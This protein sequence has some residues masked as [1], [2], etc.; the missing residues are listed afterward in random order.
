MT[1]EGTNL[2]TLAQSD[3]KCA[4]GEMQGIAFR[5]LHSI[6]CLLLTLPPSLCIII[7]TQKICILIILKQWAHREQR[8]WYCPTKSSFCVIIQV[9]YYMLK[10]VVK[11]LTKVI[12]ILGVACKNMF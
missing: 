4:L 2:I 10:Q 12:N 9:A 1:K 11:C 5:S 3:D 8:L 6:L 7:T